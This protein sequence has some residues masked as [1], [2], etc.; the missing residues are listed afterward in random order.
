M[1]A[2]VGKKGRVVL[3]KALRDRRQWSEGTRLVFFDQ[4]GGVLVMTRDEAVG[5]VRAALAGAP[6]LAGELVRERRADAV[7]E[8]RR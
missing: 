8:A 7:R 2:Q 5:A 4:P 3:P 6:S 1:V